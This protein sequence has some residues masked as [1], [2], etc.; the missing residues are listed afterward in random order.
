MPLIT[1]GE[2]H[3]ARATI[4]TLTQMGTKVESCLRQQ[5][6]LPA[7]VIAMFSHAA[8]V[9]DPG[10][11][12]DM[13]EEMKDQ[14]QRAYHE[15]LRE[16][17]I[18]DF[19][20]F[21]EFMNPDEPPARHHIFMC[22]QLM[23]LDAGESRR[24]MISMPPGHAKSTYS[25]HLF[26]AWRIGKHNRKK[27]I[28]AGHSQSFCENQIGKVVRGLVDSERYREVFPEVR[29]SADSKAAGFWTTTNGCSYLTRAIG[30]G[31]AGFRAHCGAV[32]DPFAS[33]EDAESEVIRNKVYNWYTADFITR[34]LPNCP[35]YIVA[36]R[37]HMD[38]LCGR[39]EQMN[40]E[41]K[42]IP[43]E[44]I[45]LPATAK[46]NDPLGRAPDEPLWPE[47]FDLEYLMYLKSTLPSR[48]WNSLYMGTPMDED[49]GVVKGTWFG[50]Y[51]EVPEHTKD[52]AGQIVKRGYI[53]T[54]L[55]VDSAEKT[56]K[57]ND[58]S[59][60]TVW[61][62]TPD[63]KHALVDVK[64]KRVEFTG[65][66]DLIETT[67][68]TWGADAILVEDRGSGTQYIQARG[69]SG[70]APAP[71]IPVTVTSESKQFRFDGVSPMF[72]AGEVLLPERAP[73]LAD[74]EAELLA[75]PNGSHDDQVDSTSQYLRYA[76]R[77]RARGTKKLGG[78]S[79]R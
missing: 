67:A 7:P 64:R 20:A 11:I 78:T 60:V 3:K 37:W 6:P 28:Q 14:A 1:L 27:F 36:T 61:R 4:N 35:L 73:W 54:I 53:R 42:G 55:S 59:V 40:K 16:A 77:G 23:R 69:V 74:Y 52:Q 38:D 25:S 33:R 15:R 12:L 50:R 72:Q 79:Y 17:A 63:R 62:E 47:L 22:E 8:D 26:P 24:L 56:T 76:R 32:D 29:L 66:V 71:V 58:F 46:D 30:Q 51:T 49:G 31:I 19:T 44:I 21:A 48:D 18:T 70:L 5:K 65:L 34:L 10:S 2:R 45:N 13:I 57:R 41:G 9:S 39:I 68:R 43:F 75:F